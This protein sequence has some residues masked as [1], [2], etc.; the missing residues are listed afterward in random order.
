[1][2]HGSSLSLGLAR[3]GARSVEWLA[4]VH[5]GACAY[6]GVPCLVELPMPPSAGRAQPGR[7]CRGSV[8]YEGLAGIVSPMNAYRGRSTLATD[9]LHMTFTF[10]T[11]CR[12]I[13]SIEPIKQNTSGL[14]A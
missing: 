6:R 10:C 4:V 9:I 14:D 11:C 2:T 13:R 8:I 3:I 5:L 12:S 7:L 1:M